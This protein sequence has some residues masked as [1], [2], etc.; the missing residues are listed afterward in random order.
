[1]RVTVV[2]CT[3]NRAEHLKRAL[4]SITLCEV[5]QGT[6]LEVLVV[7]NNSTDG[8]Q[9]VCQAFVNEQPDRFRYLFEKRQGKS[10]ALNRAIEAAR[11][12]I[13]AFTDDDI[14]VDAAW[15]SE[16]LKIFDRHTCEG[17][18]GKIVAVWN[19]TPPAWLDFDKLMLAIMQY[20][21]GDNPCEIK[22]PA[23]GANM[24]FRRSV[25]E[26]YGIFRTDLGPSAGTLL[27]GEDTEFCQRLMNQG[28]K[29]IYTPR[30]IVYHPVEKE[31]TEKRYFELWYFDHG[32]KLVRINGVPSDA[33]RY[34]GVP[35]YMLRKLLTS[36]WSWMTA[37]GSQPRFHHRLE[38]LQTLG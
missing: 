17:V 16:L 1:M 13:I 29:M 9:L 26:N 3:W 15:L 24:A 2:I 20:D 38:V 35:R 19:S 25:F 31:R 23:F 18:A 7:D 34:F 21:L 22:T 6:V 4:K 10:Y 28:G 12:D 8:T 27:R 37:F 36:W 14:T 11:G 32:R 30:A 5:P 33:R